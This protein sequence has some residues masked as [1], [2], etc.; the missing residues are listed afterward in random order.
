MSKDKE[1][2][3]KQVDGFQYVTLDST[4][5]VNNPNC[6]LLGLNPGCK[7]YYDS[8]TNTAYAF[9]YPNDDTTQYLYESYSQ[10]SPIDGVTDE[11]FIVWM[12]PSILP[13]FR[14]LYGSIN[15]TFNDGDQLVIDVTANFEVGSFDGKKGLVI[16]TIGDYGGK[17][18]F[19][20]QA[21]LTVG[22]FSFL[23]GLLLVV[24]EKW[25]NQYL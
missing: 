8:A 15:G 6:Q 4:A 2:L 16:S 3:Y 13:T 10:I 9:Y 25:L 21:Y 18:L 17:N 7:G 24:K 23:F 11:H 22:L 20:G 12:K 14:K 5:D 19:P 1:D